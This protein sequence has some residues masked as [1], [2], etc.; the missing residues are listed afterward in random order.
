MPSEDTKILEFN[1]GQMSH[2]VPFIIYEDLECIK[3]KING[4]KN[5]PKFIYN[6][7]KR[8]YSIRFF[9]MYAE[10]KIVWKS[11]VNSKESTQWK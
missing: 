1:Q 2:K 9:I 3:E 10:V 8:A 7:S 11:F 6:K 4:C 5:N